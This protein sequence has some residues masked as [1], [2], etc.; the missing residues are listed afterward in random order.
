M[1]A[2]FWQKP[3]HTFQL[4][5]VWPPFFKSRLPALLSPSIAEAERQAAK[6]AARFIERLKRGVRA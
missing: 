2:P 1:K 5:P 4:V 6:A 3:G